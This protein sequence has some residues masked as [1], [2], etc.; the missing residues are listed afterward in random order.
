VTS[1]LPANDEEAMIAFAGRMLAD[2]EHRMTA[3]YSRAWLDAM[4]RDHLERGLLETLTV[5]R[6]AEE[7]GDDMAHD[8]LC[9]HYAEIRD[10]HGAP[11]VTLE[12]YVIKTLATGPV[13]RKRG[14]LWRDNWHR[15]IGIAVLVHLV[16]E[17]F[18]IPRT[19]NRQE[20]RINTPS[21]SG[22]VAAALGRRHTNLSES[23]V[24]NISSRYNEGVAAYLRARGI[25]S[26][27]QGVPK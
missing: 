9:R 21:A 20:R 27:S 22:I 24:A 7:R 26:A 25:A 10:R 17:R 4:M 11:S 3:D 8:A 12:A 13:R 18:G 5:I 2:V 16:A 23:A 15:D 6:W 1:L 19:R 14:H